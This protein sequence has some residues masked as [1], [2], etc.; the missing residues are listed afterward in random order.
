MALTPLGLV[1]TAAASFGLATG[2]FQLLRPRRDA[3][4]RRV[5]YGYVGAMVVANGSALTIYKFSGGFNVFHALALYNL[6]GV[7]MA[8]RPFFAKPTP[9]Q[10]RSMHYQWIAWSYAGLSAAAMTEFLL[11]VVLLPAWMSTLFG[12][13]PPIAIGGLLIR[14]FAPPRRPPPT[15]EPA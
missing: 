3:L 4:H 6:F 14:R 13:L 11:R 10:W 1:H 12:T 7:A 5:G 15:A 2:A 9:W 8:L